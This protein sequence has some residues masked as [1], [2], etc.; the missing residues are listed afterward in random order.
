MPCYDPFTFNHTLDAGSCE[1][2]QQ[3]ALEE[4]LA[5]VFT[6][7][8]HGYYLLAVDGTDFMITGGAG[9]TL[10]EG[11]H[12]HVEVTV[13][14]GDFSYEKV[15]L[16]TDIV[17]SEHVSLAGKDGQVVNITFEELAAM[18]SESAYSSYENLY[19]N[20]AGGGTYS[21][22]TV[23]SLIALVGGMAEGDTLRVTSIDGYVQEFG[24]L[25][26]VPS[27]EWALL[28]GSMVLAWSFDGST[29]PDWEEGPRLA[30]LAPD[31]VY[32]N[33][34]CELTSYPD[35]GWF[36]YPSAGARWSKNVAMIEVI[37]GP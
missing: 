29:M 11:V 12:H 7:H 2:V 21:G 31:G 13:S 17:P 32:G 4:G 15:D 19:G 37:A 8:V 18:E 24:Y 14:D 35:Q 30:F 25:N 10:T 16:V 20:I 9:G 3:F 33:E 5:A 26:V 1:R 27:E 36:D 34:D 22:P 28:Q 23:A 6:G